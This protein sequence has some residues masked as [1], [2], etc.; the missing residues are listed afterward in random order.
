MASG[1]AKNGLYWCAEAP[2][3]P[4]HP[5]IIFIHASWMS[6]SMWAETVQSLLHQLPKVNLVRV[7]LNGHG[8]TTDGRKEYS[9]WEQAHDVLSLLVGYSSIY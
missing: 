5:S 3:Q 6:S 1:F 9:L 7:D 8:K 4:D 2:L